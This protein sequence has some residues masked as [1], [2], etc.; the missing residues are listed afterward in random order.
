MAAS[1]SAAATMTATAIPIS[2]PDGSPTATR[3]GCALRDGLPPA[4]DGPGLGD[5]G[6]GR[7]A[8]SDGWEGRG[9]GPAVREGCGDGSGVRPPGVL[10]PG[11]PGCGE[12]GVRG[13]AYAPAEREP[14]DDAAARGWHTEVAR[15]TRV[16]ARLQAHLQRLTRTTETGHSC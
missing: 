1:V 7:A 15:H 12:A 6:E 4:D 2:A 5:V 3:P 10:V 16:I 14:D 11:R 9:D 8:G 13:G